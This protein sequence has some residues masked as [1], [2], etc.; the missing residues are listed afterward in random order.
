MGVQYVPVAE[1][2]MTGW[3]AGG[4]AGTGACADGATL[5]RPIASQP[6]PPCATLTSAPF[7][8]ACGSNTPTGAHR[9]DEA[10]HR[11]GDPPAAPAATSERPP[12]ARPLTVRSGVAVAARTAWPTCSRAVGLMRIRCGRKPPA[13]VPGWLFPATT[14]VPPGPAARPATP[15]PAPAVVWCQS[16]PRV[17]ENATS[18]PCTAAATTKP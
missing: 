10:S 18:D 4:A 16:R 6:S 5:P 11:A 14:T 15:V 12:A 9:P 7:R 3:D 2:R 13:P 17:L 8:H 1:V